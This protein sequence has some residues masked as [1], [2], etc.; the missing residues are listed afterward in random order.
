MSRYQRKSDSQTRIFALSSL[1]LTTSLFATNQA[2][3]QELQALATEQSEEISELHERI[4]A[5][6]D[7]RSQAKKTLSL[8]AYDQSQEINAL[9][10][11]CPTPPLSCCQE[12]MECIFTYYAPLEESTFFAG[13]EYLLWKNIQDNT[14]YVVQNQFF[15]GTSSGAL[16]DFV[17]G[18]FDWQSGV[19]VNAGYRFCPNYWEVE[20]IYTFFKNS[21]SR[22][23][24]GSLDQAGYILVP[25]ESQSVNGRIDRANANLGLTYNGLDVLLAK[26]FLLNNDIILKPFFGVTALWIKEKFQYF[27]HSNYPT[28]SQVDIG[29]KFTYHYQAAGIKNGF[30]SDWLI[31]KGFSGFAELSFAGLVGSYEAKGQMKQYHAPSSDITYTL[32]DYKLDETWFALASHLSFGPSWNSNCKGHNVSVKCLYEINPLFNLFI[33]N[34]AAI[35][36]NPQD[37]LSRRNTKGLICL[38]GLTASA[39]LTY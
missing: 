1:L 21:G 28:T 38:Q 10:P 20:G 25:T 17:V 8:I 34:R 37:G 26:R 16:G 5:V 6:K 3:I 22:T 4:E 23:I 39:T 14:D 24:G 30:S 29:S 31:G 32:R 13:A 19:R 18:E 15:Y 33:V 11:P 9:T 12:N 7:L 36:G 35:G 2:K 27:Y